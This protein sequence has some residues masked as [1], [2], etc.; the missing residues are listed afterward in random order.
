MPGQVEN[1]LILVTAANA[2]QRLE[3]YSHLVFIA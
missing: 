1:T 2:I 3:A